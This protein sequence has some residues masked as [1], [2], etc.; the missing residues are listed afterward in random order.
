MFSFQCNF[1]SFFH[2]LIFFLNGYPSRKKVNL[3]RSCEILARQCYVLQDSCKI[4]ARSCK[5]KFFLQNLVK[6]LQELTFLCNTLART[7]KISFFGRKKLYQK[8]LNKQKKRSKIAERTVLGP[9]PGS[10]P[11]NKTF[12]ETIEPSTIE[13]KKKWKTSQKEKK[14][15]IINLPHGIK[16]FA[17]FLLFFFFYFFFFFKILLSIVLRVSYRVEE[18]LEWKLSVRY[19]LWK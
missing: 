8:T 7:C 5:I 1:K 9:Y 18:V 15:R 17:P 12:L 10:Y 11:C 2:Q 4:I 19:L 3:A 13:S 6:I 16:S 14:L